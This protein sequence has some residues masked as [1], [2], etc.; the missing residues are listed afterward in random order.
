LKKE[1]QEEDQGELAGAEEAVILGSGEDGQ[2]RD[3]HDL[4]REG[5]RRRDR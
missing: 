3:R 5:D 4:I 2:A 1:R